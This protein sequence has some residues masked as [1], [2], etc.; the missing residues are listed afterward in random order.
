M[1][2]IKTRFSNLVFPIRIPPK[3][4]VCLIRNNNIQVSKPVTR[5]I[6][7]GNRK[8]YI[9]NDDIYS[10][11]F[12]EFAGYSYKARMIYSRLLNIPPC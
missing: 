8:I 6:Q 3:Y 5:M 11:V 4:G 2:K 7:I 1:L 10:S 9:K 12:S